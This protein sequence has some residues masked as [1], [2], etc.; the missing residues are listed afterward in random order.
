MNSGLIVVLATFV[1]IVLL[2][3]YLKA[4][5]PRKIKE[6]NGGGLAKTLPMMNRV[7]GAIA[8]IALPIFLAFLS[9]RIGREES[10]GYPADLNGSD[11]T[12]FGVKSELLHFDGMR[13]VVLQ[14]V[15]S[16]TKKEVGRA[17]LFNIGESPLPECPLVIVI[18]ER[19]ATAD[20][21]N[22]NWVFNLYPL[23]AT[24]KVA[25]GT[26]NVPAAEAKN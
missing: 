16:A 12:V 24:N 14:E 1:V 4:G 17:R 8:M 25:A 18:R 7:A 22:E 5:E 3:V 11:K 6:S 21:K 13:A 20:A 19:G 26:T 2:L 15:D 10:K 9:T 23:F